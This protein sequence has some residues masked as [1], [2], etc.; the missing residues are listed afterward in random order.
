MQA[1]DSARNILCR[2]EASAAR[3]VSVR[4]RSLVPAQHCTDIEINRRFPVTQKPERTTALYRRRRCKY[5]RIHHACSS[6]DTAVVHTELNS[7]SAHS[8]MHG[9]QSFFLLSNSTSLI[10]MVEKG[11]GTIFYFISHT[12]SCQPKK[13]W[14]HI[15]R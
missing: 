2:A 4:C 14:L 6:S 8:Y 1:Y 13:L 3:T 12:I 7:N 9:K 10:T 5:E 11:V 15:Y